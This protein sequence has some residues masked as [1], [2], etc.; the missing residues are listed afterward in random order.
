MVSDP[1]PPGCLL[2]EDSSRVPSYSQCL[3]PRR[4]LLLTR[5]SE[6][7]TSDSPTR[8]QT[9]QKGIAVAAAYKMAL[10]RDP[11][12]WKRFSTAV[13]LDEEAKVIPSEASTPVSETYVHPAL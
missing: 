7:T 2:I 3:T 11:Y 12:F 4:Q 9:Y 1:A 5:P 8:T 6:H 10:V 13:H